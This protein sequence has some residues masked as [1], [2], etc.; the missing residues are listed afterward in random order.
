[1]TN[2]PSQQLARYFAGVAE[3][4]FQTQ[5]GVADP[6]L[7]DY[8]SSLLMRFVRVD[9]MHRVRNL[10]GQPVRRVQEMLAEAGE[11]VGEAR[12]EVHRHIGD[13]TLFWAGIFPEALRRKRHKVEGDPFLDYCVQGKRAYLIASTI[14]SEE[15]DAPGD[16]LHRLGEQF[17]MCAYGMREV[18]REWE[19][20]EDSDPDVGPILFN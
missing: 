15:T 1:M 5:L 17:E 14:E 12:R 16:L 2:H 19:R 8:I 10:Q 6:K 11:R 4:V 9:Q 7:T 18:R 20:R 3:H 13:F